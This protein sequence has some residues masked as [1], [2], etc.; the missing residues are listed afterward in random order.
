[1]SENKC[2]VIRFRVTDSERERI[3]KLANRVS[4]GNISKLIKNLIEREEA[5]QMKKLYIAEY[6]TTDSIDTL[7]IATFKRDEAIAEAGYEWHHL[8]DAE[9]DR[10]PINVMA[11]DVPDACETVE[12]ATD[13]LYDDHIAAGGEL[14][15]ALKA[16]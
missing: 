4:G 1:M 16:E 15:L 3:Q 11:Y 10:R 14:V 9:K 7:V 8:T 13:W 6:D 12:D 5:N 2:D